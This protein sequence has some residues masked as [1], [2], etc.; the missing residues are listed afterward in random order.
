MAFSKIV[1]L[2]V[3]PRTPYSSINRCS[4]PDLSMSRLRLS[5]QKLCPYFW[6]STVELTVGSTVGLAVG[7]TVMN[8]SQTCIACPKRTK[9][10]QSQKPD[11]SISKRPSSQTGQRIQASE[12]SN[13]PLVMSV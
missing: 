3:T 13:C 8:A 5:Y 7:L 6:T 4:S 11:V 1:G 2:E 12:S 9:V 10:P